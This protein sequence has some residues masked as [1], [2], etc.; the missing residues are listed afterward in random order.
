MKTLTW[1][2]VAWVSSALIGCQT[3]V[4]TLVGCSDS[5]AIRFSP[6]LVDG[7]YELKVQAAEISQHCSFEVRKDGQEV[8]DSTCDFGISPEGVSLDEAPALVTANLLWRD[9]SVGELNDVKP[10]YEDYYP[11]GPACDETP[12]RQG[13]VTMNVAYP[14][15][16][17]GE[18]GGR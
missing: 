10:K 9:V 18:G 11:N 4:C 13:E 15:G 14:S 6:A 8:G 7:H 16:G 3:K 17:G 2:W 1:M 12:C 5:L